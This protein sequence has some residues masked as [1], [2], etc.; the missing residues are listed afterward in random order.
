[1]KDRTARE[2]VVYGPAWDHVHGGYFSD[3][4]VAR[5]LV[6]AAWKAFRAAKPGVIVDV[7]GGTGFVLR[8]L[9]ARGLP[10]GVRLINLDPSTRQLRADRSRRI[11]TL[12][13]SLEAFERPA[14]GRVM[15]I[16]RS[17]LHYE[18]RSGLLPALRR[19][20]AQA[21]DGELFIH[22]TACFARAD[23]ARRLNEVYRLMGT[24]KWYP[25]IAAL[26]RALR[27]TGWKVLSESRARPLKLT[28]SDLDRRYALGAR[29]IRRIRQNVPVKAGVF[30]RTPSG[31]TARLH[32]RIFTCEAV[33]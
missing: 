26:R 21:K 25:T 10:A 16:M 32:Y 20:R 9:V 30:V 31:F 22:Q 7:G 8:R 13:G 11:R 12:R 6:E 3:P 14:G 27:R 19:L 24:T 23:D 5:P 18:G 29:R 1:M 15:L 28:S 2:R 17:A 33:S 4:S